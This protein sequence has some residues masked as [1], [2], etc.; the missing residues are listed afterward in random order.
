M[1]R[2]TKAFDLFYKRLGPTG[3]VAANP[4]TS[5][6]GYLQSDWFSS[7]I[8]SSAAATQ[9]MRVS[10]AFLNFPNDVT[11]SWQYVT[12]RNSASN[13]TYVGL[14]WGS[15]A[16]DFLWNVTTPS[17][18]YTDVAG[19]SGSY[20]WVDRVWTVNYTNKSFYRQY[21]SGSALTLGT[22]SYN[23]TSSWVALDAKLA[24][25]GT[26]TYLTTFGG[27]S[28]NPTFVGAT[29]Q[30]LANGLAL[31]S[32][33]LIDAATQIEA[34]KTIGYPITYPDV[35]SSLGVLSKSPVDN[36]YF[37]I[38]GGVGIT[39]GSISA[40]LTTASIY[41]STDT[42]FAQN[43]LTQALKARRLYFP[44]PLSAS[45]TTGGTDY[46]FKTFTGYQGNEV[47]DE[48][49]GI[50][51]VRFTL[52]SYLSASSAVDYKP[53][54]GSFMTVFIHDVQSSVPFTT[55]RVPGAA[56]WYPPPNNIITI[57]N[58][59]N[60]TPEF[61]FFDLQTGYLVEKF[62]INVIQYGYPAQLCIEASGSLDDESYFGIVVDELEICKVG[63]TTDPRF[64]KP[65]SITQQ[66]NN[67][68]TVIALAGGVEDFGGGP[69]E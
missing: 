12:T 27:G 37:D 62:N 45:G 4:T 50:Y 48:N 15:H 59:Y 67:K 43:L 55:K 22:S 20:S 31:A 19:S 58:K 46:W 9:G 21:G 16:G 53:D 34:S 35:T 33:S 23:V 30:L 60:G 39:R 5:F 29:G 52:K 47:F 11:N 26:F 69:A 38:A 36:Q 44:I 65:T 6:A 1:G 28:V 25:V 66:V 17:W 2:I 32:G 42:L 10:G 57:A 56:G 64:I 7:I 51:N 41:G 18:S 24:G 63:V 54:T 61:S 49:G 3:S 14:P 8:S 13:A 40:S 68:T